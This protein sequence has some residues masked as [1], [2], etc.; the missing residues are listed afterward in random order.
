FKPIY[1]FFLSLIIVPVVN[2]A[3]LL[4][5]NLQSDPSMPV[6]ISEQAAFEFW[7][8]GGLIDLVRRGRF[9]SGNEI[10]RL[11]RHELVLSIILAW[12]LISL[13]LTLLWMLARRLLQR[14][15]QPRFLFVLIISIVLVGLLLPPVIATQPTASNAHVSIN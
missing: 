9:P 4:S 1:P 11:P 3:Y 10:L 7:M 13:S 2:A 12:F 14:F 6:S 5:L 8:L 15:V